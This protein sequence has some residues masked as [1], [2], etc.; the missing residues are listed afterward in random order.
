MG[1]VQQC[2]ARAELIARVK[3]RIKKRKR[4]ARKSLQGN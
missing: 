3:D 4:R 2:D 1:E